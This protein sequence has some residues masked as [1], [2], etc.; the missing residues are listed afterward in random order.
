MLNHVTSPEDRK[1]AIR[2]ILARGQVRSQAH[3]MRE[4]E[5]IGIVATQP[6]VS[7]DLRALQVKKRRGVYVLNDPDRVTR[8]EILRSLLRGV[9]TAGPHLVVVDCEPGAA[10]AIARALEADQQTGV[11]GTVAGDDTV[12]VAVA[13]LTAGRRIV[14]RME[15]LLETGP[16]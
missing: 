2:Q 3:L 11:V 14:R 15:Q 13:S 4:L 12:F 8:L 1:D 16:Q 10:S 6:V 7:R 9:A 5:A